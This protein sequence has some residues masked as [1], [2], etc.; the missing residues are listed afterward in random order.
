MSYR[1][2]SMTIILTKEE[3]KSPCKW[4]ALIILLGNYS[5]HLVYKLLKMITDHIKIENAD[6]KNGSLFWEAGPGNCDKNGQEDSKMAKFFQK[7]LED[8]NFRGDIRH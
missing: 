7:M 5:K 2:D 3:V 8:C 6:K 4:K 1:Q